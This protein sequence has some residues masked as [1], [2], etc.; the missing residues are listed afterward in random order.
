[1]VS[2]STRTKLFFL[3]EH[4]KRQMQLYLKT[5][6]VTLFKSPTIL[7]IST[8]LSKLKSV[9]VCFTFLEQFRIVKYLEAIVTWSPM[10][11]TYKASPR[12]KKETNTSL[13]V[14]H[15]FWE[16]FED[17]C[18]ESSILTCCISTFSFGVIIDVQFN[19]WSMAPIFKVTKYQDYS[20]IY[21]QKL[22]FFSC[23]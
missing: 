23:F 12:T 2:K 18:F 22:N 9:I 14:R 13:L 8:T 4:W 21:R 5:T 19:T 16:D 3:N 17:F 20:N 10:S 6:S 1:M 7:L 15:G 11:V